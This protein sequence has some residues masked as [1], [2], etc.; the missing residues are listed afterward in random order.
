MG[1]P[2]VGKSTLFNALTRAAVAASNYP[3]CTVDPNLSVV[4]V[5]LLCPE[6]I[7]DIQAG[8]IH[9]KTL[10]AYASHSPRA[11]A[12]GGSRCFTDGRRDAGDPRAHLRALHRH[13]PD[14][15]VIP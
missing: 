7:K 5:A 8:G 11:S 13:L 9:L 14:R 4:P 2:N 15:T 6:D 12:R 1:L 3:F 10:C